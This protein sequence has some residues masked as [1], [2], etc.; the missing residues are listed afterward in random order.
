MPL[1]DGDHFLVNCASDFFGCSS[2]AGRREE[3]GDI[4]G[5]LQVQPVA[6][7][8]DVTIGGGWA[9]PDVVVAVVLAYGDGDAEQVGQAIGGQQFDFGAVGCDAA[10][11]EHYHAIDF[12]RDVG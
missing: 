11:A 10:L 7:N 2:A 3:L 1:R 4:L 12:R 9:L 6:Q 8:G 5:G